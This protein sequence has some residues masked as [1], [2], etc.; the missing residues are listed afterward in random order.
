M[1][2]LIFPPDVIELNTEHHNKNVPIIEN[3]IL[4]P[5]EIYIYKI[6]N[7]YFK[8][9]SSEKIDLMISIIA[10]N[11]IISLRILDW[12]STIYS[13]TNKVQWKLIDG[14]DFNVNSSYKAQ[15]LTYKKK[16][17]DPFRRVKPDDKNSKFY[18]AFNKKNKS[19]RVLTT[20]AQLNFFKWAFSNKII[21]YIENN[22]D[23]ISTKMI[24]LNKMKLQNKKD[25][26][27][28]QKKYDSDKD[29]KLF[30]FI[31]C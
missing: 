1:V 26:N 2:H 23:S 16:Y 25:N 19:I 15:L 7:G 24:P 27:L 14:S 6:I 8:T 31:N 18:Y 30:I 5:H 17:F 12:F 28:K 4:N 13:V 10:R 29:R 3:A 21:E 22:Y 20:L 9:L 11:N